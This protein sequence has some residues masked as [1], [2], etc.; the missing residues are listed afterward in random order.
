MAR[1]DPNSL[2]SVL[3]LLIFEAEEFQ[4]VEVQAVFHTSA[5]F[6]AGDDV[7]EV[8]YWEDVFVVGAGFGL[9]EA[10]DAIRGENEIEVKGAVLESG[11]AS[12]IHIY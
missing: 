3:P 7:E 5:G 9:G 1:L 8:R 11:Q 6:F 2:V 10:F 12:S 4:Q